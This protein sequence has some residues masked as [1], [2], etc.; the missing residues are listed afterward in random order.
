METM[1]SHG[2]TSVLRPMGSGLVA[3]QVPG[4]GIASAP[5]DAP[6]EVLP[7]LP[8]SL[9][10]LARRAL[11]RAMENE[12]ELTQGWVDSNDAIAWH[13]GVQLILDA[14]DTRD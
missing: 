14:L 3:S 5:D 11:H 6:K 10:A 1:S 4:S 8:L 12:Y 7:Q 13:Q 2:T 9:Y